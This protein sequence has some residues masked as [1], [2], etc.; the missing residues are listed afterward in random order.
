MTIAVPSEHVLS[1]VEAYPAPVRE[2]TYGPSNR[3]YC[4]VL[5]RAGAKW[6]GPIVMSAQDLHCF[7][8]E[9][10]ADAYHYHEEVIANPADVRRLKLELVVNGGTNSNS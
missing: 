8:A 9:L 7:T 2:D 5:Y 4:T 10:P 3:Q 1:Q 6:Y